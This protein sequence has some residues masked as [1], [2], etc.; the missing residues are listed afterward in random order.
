MRK[1][2][3]ITALAFWWALRPSGSP[4]DVGRTVACLFVAMIVTGGLGG[5][6]AFAG[7]PWYAAYADDVSPFGWTPLEDQQV[8]GLIMWIPGGTLYM[9]VALLRMHEVLAPRVLRH[10]RT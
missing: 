2:L 9:V 4:S 6:L 8:G 3:F 10:A 1:L 7:T 5:L